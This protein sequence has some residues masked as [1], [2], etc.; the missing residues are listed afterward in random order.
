MIHLS[1]DNLHIWAVS[2]SL[3]NFWVFSRLIQRKILVENYCNFQ[4]S[5]EDSTIFPYILQNKIELQK[6]LIAHFNRTSSLRIQNDISQ[7]ICLSLYTILCSLPFVCEF[8]E[9]DK[10]HIE[11]T[12]KILDCVFKASRTADSFC[13]QFAMFC[14]FLK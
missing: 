2:A 7:F 14:V 11:I 10:V 8:F 13:L 4:K 5:N 6:V 3:L 12:S 9:R 1:H